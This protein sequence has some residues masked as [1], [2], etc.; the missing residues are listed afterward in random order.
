MTKYQSVEKSEVLSSEDHERIKTE[1][2][3]IG[4]TNVQNL[5]D[6]ERRRV[7]NSSE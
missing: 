3:R 4:K 6:D 2:R 7:L 1:L 5:T